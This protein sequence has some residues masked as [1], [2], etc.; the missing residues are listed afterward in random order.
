MGYAGKLSP[1][2]ARGRGALSNPRNRFESME[3]IPEP[4]TEGYSDAEDSGNVLKTQHFRDSS[5]SIITRNNSPDVGFDK[6]LNPYR[7]C[8]HGCVYCY[9]RPTHE[10]LGFSAGLDFETKIV[11][12]EDAPRLLE[13]EL[14]SQ[15]W[16]P[17][18]LAMSGVTDPYQPVEKK[19]G[20]TRGCLEVLARLRNPVSIITKNSLVERDIDYLSELARYQ[21][22]SVTLSITTLDAALGRRME[23]R[24]SSPR[25]RLQTIERLTDACIPAG[26]MIAPVIPGLN[27]EEIPRILQAA[28]KAGAKFAGYIVLRLPYANK[29]LFC[30]WLERHYAWE[31]E[32][33]LSRV[34]D[35]RGGKLNN[36]EFGLRMKGRGIW[37]EQL[38]QLFRIGC[39]RAGLQNQSP[40]LSTAHFRPPAGKQLFL[41]P[42]K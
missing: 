23:P 22:V 40:A 1:L 18:V 25:Q 20:I 4:D 12:K 35:L 27:E 28:V 14:S 16:K 15:R 3:F 36:P 41:L 21:A 9:A 7:G 34:K 19:L 17:E 37:A 33:I 38:R 26:V 2:P 39:R 5:C 13:K 11:V 42:E 29:D 31:K 8:E 6:S 30:D 10:Y 24:T 32:K